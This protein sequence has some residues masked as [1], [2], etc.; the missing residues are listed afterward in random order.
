MDMPTTSRLPTTSD[1]DELSD[2]P[3]VAEPPQTEIQPK[4][5]PAQKQKKSPAIQKLK[6]IVKKNQK[7]GR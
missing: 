2:R 4:T 3:I 5:I 7:Q 1:C 6:E